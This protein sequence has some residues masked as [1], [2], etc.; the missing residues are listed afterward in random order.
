MKNVKIL[1]IA[2][3]CAGLFASCEKKDKEVVNVATFENISLGADSINS[4]PSDGLQ[5]WSSGD[6]G[7][8][9]GVAYEGT[10]YYNYVVSNQ[11]SSAF[12]DFTDQYHS[13][14]GGP[15]AGSNFAVAYLDSYTED[16]SLNISYTGIATFIPGTY[17]TNNAYAASV[18]KTGNDY[19]RAFKEG[20]Y[21]KLT[22]T[23]YLA[24]VKCGSVDFYLAD[25]RNGK[26]LIV[27]DWVYVELTDLGIVD[28]IRCSL[29]STDTGDYGMNT[30]AYFCIDN[31]GA[32]K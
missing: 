18:I 26:S 23:G 11:K 16:A 8:S 30:P 9:T 14:P 17:V 1:A 31:F 7:F 28:E 10:Y 13:A 21:F 6:F 27:K 24:G 25:Y 19:S 20:D 4:Y 22:F 5:K 32:K 2:L 15:V 3:V 29:T 12:S